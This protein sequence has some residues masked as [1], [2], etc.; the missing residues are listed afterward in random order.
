M[1]LY[2]LVS[3]I[4][5]TFEDQPCFMFSETCLQFV[6]IYFRCIRQLL[7]GPLLTV[8]LLLYFLIQIIKT[9]QIQPF[10]PEEP[11]KWLFTIS[12]WKNLISLCS[13]STVVVHWYYR[14][15]LFSFTPYQDISVS[16]A[17]DLSFL[18]NATVSTP[19][20]TLTFP[21]SL[22]LCQNTFS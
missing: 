18:K 12:G 22:P 14:S 2:L 20:N 11:I 8:K 9:H 17:T 16:I 19:W 4:I 3:D 7:P 10:I 5:E 13:V 15:T 6:F 21:L 1:A